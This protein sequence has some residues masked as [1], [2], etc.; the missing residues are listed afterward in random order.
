MF[1]DSSLAWIQ[2]V[3]LGPN[4]RLQAAVASSPGPTAASDTVLG[5]LSFI[6]DSK[7]V[8]RQH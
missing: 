7:Q 5:G 8:D 1:V 3:S 2:F 6:N 4:V